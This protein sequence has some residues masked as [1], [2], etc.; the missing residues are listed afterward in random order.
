M[1]ERRERQPGCK[2]PP[3]YKESDW[4][5][6]DPGIRKAVLIL[7]EAGIETFE[8]CEGGPGHS[9]PEPTIR[10]AGGPGDGWKALGRCLALNLQP[11]EL[12]LVWDVLDRNFPTGPHWEITFREKLC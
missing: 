2:G 12:R 5:G 8:S 3:I 6:L 10:F 4:P 11:S 7:D 9:F 1:I